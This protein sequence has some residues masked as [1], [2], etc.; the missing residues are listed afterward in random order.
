MSLSAANEIIRDDILAAT[1]VVKTDMETE[2]I[3][4]P[5]GLAKALTRATKIHYT[6]ATVQV[7]KTYEVIPVYSKGPESKAWGGRVDH[8]EAII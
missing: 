1:D 6:S 5:V 2:A 8:L 4:E 3:T 7:G